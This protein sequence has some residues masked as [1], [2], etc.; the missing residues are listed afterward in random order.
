MPIVNRGMIMINNVEFN[1][2]PIRPGEIRLLMVDSDSSPIVLAI[3]CFREPPRPAQ[4]QPCQECG[5]FQITSGEYFDVK[6]PFSVF[7]YGGGY[8]NLCVQD[9]DGD[10][11]EFRLSVETTGTSGGT[12]HASN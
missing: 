2:S 10:E 12:E 3:E 11:R 6:A 7:E 5:T 4:L 9:S 8:V 1:L